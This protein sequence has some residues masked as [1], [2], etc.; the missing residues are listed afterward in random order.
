M[1]YNINNMNINKTNFYGVNKMQDEDISFQEQV[2]DLVE[3]VTEKVEDNRIVPEYGDFSPVLE[4]IP[5]LDEENKTVGK[6]GLKIYKMPKDVVPDPKKRY[7]E[8]SAY[9]PEGDYKATLVVGSGDKDEIIKQLKA[10]EFPEKLNRAY[11]ELLEML[12]DL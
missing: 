6:Y 9:V 1:N 11:G 3:R 7:I 5:N 8:A 10:P 4:F 12:E 2:D